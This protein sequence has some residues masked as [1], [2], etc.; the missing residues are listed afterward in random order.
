MLKQAHV[1]L[2]PA[3]D[4]SLISL[5]KG[6]ESLDKMVQE[7]LQEQLDSLQLAIDMLLTKNN[8]QIFSKDLS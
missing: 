8:D 6:F 1:I 4:M 5:Q 7:E 2:G 3:Q